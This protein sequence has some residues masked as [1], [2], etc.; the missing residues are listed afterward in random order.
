MP[1]FCTLR[2]FV[3]VKKS[4]GKERKKIARFE[5]APAHRQEDFPDVLGTFTARILI[6]V[7]VARVVDSA[8]CAAA[9]LREAKD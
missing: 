7:A 3:L 9:L 4:V 6:A 2:F 1:Q 5:S 8:S